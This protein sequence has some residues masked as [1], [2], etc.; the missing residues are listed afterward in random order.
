MTDVPNVPG[1]VVRGGLP[2]F[3]HVPQ[4]DLPP[5]VTVVPTYRLYSPGQVGLATFFGSPLAGGI[6]LAR[7]FYRLGERGR[8]WLP[9]VVAFL[10][11]L[12]LFA[13]GASTEAPRFLGLVPLGL[14]IWYAEAQQGA[15]FK[16][17]LERGGRRASHWHAIGIALATAAGILGAIFTV[18]L[19]LDHFTRN[20]VEVPPRGEVIY[21]AGAT[22]SEAK[23]VAKALSELDYFLNDRDITVVVR[24]QGQHIV[25]GLV[26]TGETVIDRETEEW[27]HAYAEPLSQRA[28]AGR[29]VDIEILDNELY[30]LRHLV[31]EKRPEKISLRG[32]KQIVV[33]RDGATGDE[34]R[35]VGA[36]LVE[37]KFFGPEDAGDVIV[38]NNGR[39]VVQFVMQDW[40]FSDETFKQMFH[41]RWP[42]LFSRKAFG[43][44][45]VDVHFVDDNLAVRVKL[46]WDKR[47]PEPVVVDDK[48]SVYALDHAF[49]VQAIAKIATAQRELGRRWVASR[50]SEDRALVEI[51]ADEAAV[52]RATFAGNRYE[53]VAKQLSDAVFAGE[54]VDVRV[55]GEK[56]MT[57]IRWESHR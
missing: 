52:D 46:E 32:E 45:P 36:V 37:N 33:N 23:A 39:A 5:G 56:R 3:D 1:A 4:S 29:P 43:G 41:A 21:E 20:V 27:A 31:W 28:F 17:H 9:L 38:T 6:L 12:G 42:P 40:T 14:M 8:A 22:E 35:A 47:P 49:D 26:V 25:V 10:G 50:T 34:A 18:V 51:T 2:R 15:R 44:A 24:H 30:A 19:A 53:R 54:P 13:I 48:L 55:T 11:T 16:Q 7:N 57:D